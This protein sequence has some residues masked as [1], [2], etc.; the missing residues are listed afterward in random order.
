MFSN[1]KSEEVGQKFPQKAAIPT[2]ND[3]S[4]RTTVQAPRKRPDGA[5]QPSFLSNHMSV[6]GN[7]ISDSDIVVEG[8]IEGDVRAQVLTIGEKAVISGQ[9]MASE[10][11]VDGRVIGQIRGTRVRL[12]K[13]ARVEGDIFHGALAI[14][15]GAHFE[16]TVKREE[17]PLSQ[18]A[19]AQPRSAQAQAPAQAQASAT[20]RDPPNR[21]SSQASQAAP[22]QTGVAPKKT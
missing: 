21:P 9:V 15:S 6:K 19:A 20:R 8:K 11:I 4:L 1:K 2:Q 12:N 7:L 22:A 17:D 5:V 18:N 14:E 10:V 3:A 16:G 13:L